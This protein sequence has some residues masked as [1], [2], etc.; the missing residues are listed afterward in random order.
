M[1]LPQSLSPAFINFSPDSKLAYVLS[2]PLS[3][4]NK[5]VSVIDVKTHTLLST[6]PVGLSFNLLL[7]NSSVVA[8]SPD[9]KYAYITNLIEGTVSVI[10]VK[11]HST[12]ST[13]QVGIAPNSL[14]ISPDGKS[15]YVRM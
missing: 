13:I 6:V 14:A 9:G 1:H 4:T 2:T 15:V 12:I 7:F 5:T 8:I 11:T 10:D 3:L